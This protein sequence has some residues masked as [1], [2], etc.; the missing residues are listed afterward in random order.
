[1]KIVLNVDYARFIHST[2]SLSWDCKINFRYLLIDSKTRKVIVSESTLLPYRIK[3]AICRVMFT[4]FQVPSVTFLSSH[5]LALASTGLR[6]G[7]VVDIGWHDTRI[8]PVL[9][10]IT[11]LILDLRITPV[12]SVYSSHSDRMQSVT[13]SSCVSPSTIHHSCIN[14]SIIQHN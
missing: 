1:L 4:Y 11:V 10:P 2:D 8:L 3:E 14:I 9:Y 5:V 6:T 7:I 12:E 13:F